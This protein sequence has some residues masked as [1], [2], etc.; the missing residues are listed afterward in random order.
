M[1]VYELRG[2]CRTELKSWT[3]SLFTAFNS[4]T[5][6]HLNR[7]PPRSRGGQLA[8][9]GDHPQEAL[10]ARKGRLPV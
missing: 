9:G 5:E 6:L 3:G 10:Q 8:L 4:W 7:R 1:A 2:R